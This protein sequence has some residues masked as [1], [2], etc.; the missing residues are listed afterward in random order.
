MAI[1][2]FIALIVVIILL[3]YVIVRIAKDA[4]DRA[5][6]AALRTR[7]Q[8]YREATNRLQERADAIEKLQSEKATL[9]AD[10]ANEKRAAAEKLKLLEDAEARL[11]TEFENLANR[12]LENK[13]KAL[14]EENRERL[15]DLLK[16]FKDQLADFR[17]RVD[18][19]H[20]DDTEQS[21]KLLEQVRQLHELSNKVSDEA[22]NL[23]KAIKGDSKKQGDWGELI[24]ERIFEASGLQRGREFDAQVGL[25][26]EDGSLKKPDFIVYLPGNKAV[27][28]DSKVSLTAFER[29][30]AD[31]DDAAKSLA[32]QDHLQSVRNHVEA[33]RSKDYTKLL[34]NKSLDFVIMCI[35]LE[36]A[37][38]TALQADQNLVYDLAKTNVVIT[39]PTTLMITLKLIAQIW[40]RE[41]ENRNAEIIADRAGRLYDQVTLIVE[42]MT[43]AQKKLS[44][45]SES[46]D[47]ALK[48]LKEGKGNL[49][50]RVEELRKLGAKVNKQLP[51]AIVEQAATD[52]DQET[53]NN[54]V[55]LTGDPL[56]GPPA[57]H[58]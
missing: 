25:R 33:L 19:V 21:A 7:D 28:V 3:G 1:A 35:P 4:P 37:Y 22:N 52:E 9:I 39:G 13:G 34:G 46:F 12:I 49:I 26:A 15:S 40:R 14:T 23:A 11:K 55:V 16:P 57:A 44:G 51:A 48:R 6:L 20:K 38:Q 8:D 42:A 18:E 32:L 54:G 56:R 27:I 43:D 30:C 58:P 17:R 29:F 31:E 5:E 47:L 41:H 10:L 2:T 50:G 53:A 24:V 45:V 36:P